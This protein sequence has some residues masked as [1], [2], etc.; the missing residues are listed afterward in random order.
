MVRTMN[1]WT[2][3]TPEAQKARE[4]RY[5]H[6]A[7]IGAEKKRGTIPQKG[8]HRRRTHPTQ[9]SHRQIPTAITLAAHHQLLAPRLVRNK[10]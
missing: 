8:L 5:L 1:I 6:S 7:I 4:L 2:D 10:E 3:D 9:K